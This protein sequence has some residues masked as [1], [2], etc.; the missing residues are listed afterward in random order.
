M[1]ELDIVEEQDIF[2][3]I[4]DL[5]PEQIYFF[6]KQKK[7]TTFDRLKDPRNTGGDFDIAKQKKVDELIKNGE[8][9]D[10]Q[11]ACE[12]DTIEA[13]DNYL[14]TWQEGK[15]RSEARERK[16]KCV[17][18]EEIIAWKAACEANSVEGYDNYLRSCKKEI[19]VIKHER[20]KLR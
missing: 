14:M 19:F 3:N 18:N 8:D 12:A 6:I 10:W 17:S 13:Y 9:Y 5:T 20:I 7:F 1:E 2:D 15:Y 11:A 16:K 4:A